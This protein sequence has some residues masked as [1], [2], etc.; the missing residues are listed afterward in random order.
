MRFQ[1]T[2]LAILLW[3]SGTAQALQP[4]QAFHHY[5]RSTW[6]IEQGLPQI[7]ALSITQDRQGYV[8]I[9]T[10]AGLARFDGVRFVNYTPDTEPNLPGILIRALHV[11]RDGR[12]W[13]ATYKGV[14]VFD[15]TS[16]KTVLAGD[17]LRWPM[18]DAFAFAEDGRGQLWVATAAGLFQILDG[19]M[20]PVAG[21]P[22]STQSLL[23]RADG[24]WVGTSGAVYRLAG[25]RWHA[26]PLPV[27]SRS[28]TAGALVETQGRVWVAT[29]QG[30][31]FYSAAG[32]RRFTDMPAK[33]KAPME[34][35]YAD[36]DGNLWAGT[37]IGLAR[38]RDGKLVE[39]IDAKGPGG[40]AGLRAGFEDREGNLWLGSQWE[41]L[42]RLHDSWTRRYSLAEGL[43]DPIVWSLA[44]DPDQRRIW[45][46]SNNGLSVLEN[47]RITQVVAGQALPD[48]HA[49]N[50]LA[51]ADRLWIGT[52]RGLVLIDHQG[53]HAGAVQQPAMLAP[54]AALQINGIV[55]GADGEHW[56]ASSDGL[57]RL[58][59]NA[60]RRY[61][62]EDGLSDARTRFF[63]RTRDGRV[64]IGT[65]GG[66]Y[67]LQGERFVPVGL[68]RG[69]PAGLDVTAITELSDG[70]LVIGTLSERLYFLQGGR[71]HELGTAQGF[72]TNAPVFFSEY[73]GYL[74]IGGIRGI[75]RVPIADLGA[76]A[77]GRMQRTRGEMLLSD[78]GDPLSGQ[79]GHCCN[80]AGNSKGFR[81]GSTL[82][83]PSRDGVV[84][85]DIKGIIKNPVQPAV[86][87]ERM[88]VGDVW[89][90]ADSM[91][92][93]RLPANDRDLSFEFTVLSFQ[94]PAS[95]TMQYRLRGYDRSWREGD[96][97]RRNARYTN[98]PPGNYVF[99]VRG[100]N[101]GGL[102]GVTP[103]RLAF[104]LQPHFHETRL[105]YLLIA[106]LLA[107]LLYGGYR[108]Q[109]HRH[110]V[111][112][113]ALEALIK[114]RTEAL[115]I[116]NQQLENANLRLEDA[117][118][119]DPLTGLRNRRYMDS[120]IPAD[121]AYFD[122]EIQLG[123]YHGEVMVFALV[124]IDHFK[125]VNDSHG[126]KAGDEVLQQFARLLLMLVRTGDYVVRWGGEEFLLVFRPM[127]AHNMVS[128]GD[129][130]RALVSSHA[131]DLGNG[132]V[133]RLTASAGLAEYPLFTDGRTQP[134]WQTMIELADRA[135][136]YVKAHGRDGWA[137]FRPTAHTD[138]ATVLNDLQQDPEAV[139]ASGKLQ[140]LASER[141]VR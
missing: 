46:G 92:R 74:W 36:R 137:A 21:S 52:R 105:F 3:L 91:R 35:L 23:S 100:F 87:I 124:D 93:A 78:R 30:L 136:Y 94:D 113:E 61:G 45:V 28:S 107:A 79:Q 66:L 131:F 114:Q 89:H 111:Q 133:L 16:F 127:S 115:E 14:A 76:L 134:D 106:L 48:P 70:R 33:A 69:L 72:P 42:T 63:Y 11:A 1:G 119:T 5:V 120:Q 10:Q 97:L 108:Y 86:V 141:S 47:G 95:N 83:L 58:Y 15:G 129:R 50:L 75:A 26:M 102:G 122:R 139:I 80:G 54:L 25:T 13:I 59:A 71:W 112:R 18:L 73:G 62:Q 60:L 132:A 118:Q 138:L 125:Q 27:E 116:A 12:L 67:V 85:M 98:L 38:I 140:V 49:Y 20:Q 34:L 68:D 109:P 7:S 19:R 56:I 2:L 126:H 37:D 22:A 29:P 17:P 121:M 51:E 53:P 65:Q 8:W 43:N 81:A 99:E 135:L 4:G 77:S 90:S 41:S 101:N 6:S 84:E 64:L 117:S 40:I 9:G 44:R 123:V 104:T 96:N 110:R 24:L 57:F 88:Q 39:Y 31:D 82:W 32:W 103:A 130:L 55:A 128:I